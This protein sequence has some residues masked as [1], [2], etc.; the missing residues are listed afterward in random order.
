MSRILDR[1]TGER[2]AQR[3]SLLFGVIGVTLLAQCWAWLGH[4]VTSGGGA[5]PLLISPSFSVS[6]PAESMPVNSSVNSPAAPTPKRNAE[7][8]SSENKL[9]RAQTSPVRRPPCAPCI[10]PETVGALDRSVGI[11]GMIGSD[12]SCPRSFRSVPPGPADVAAPTPSEAPV[13]TATATQ[14][15][16]RA[17]L[18][19]LSPTDDRCRAPVLRVR[20]RS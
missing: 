10:E 13:A 7:S 17:T 2:C 19:A 1:G 6:N 16:P 9:S 11:V 18:R 3:C 15:H 4:P 14:P 20:A 8:T 12:R 5:P